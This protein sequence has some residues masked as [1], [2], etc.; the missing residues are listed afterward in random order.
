KLPLGIG[1]L[2]LLVLGGMTRLAW[3]DLRRSARALAAERLNRV[4]PDLAAGLAG[5]A[6]TRSGSLGALA[7]DS[8]LTRFLAA[9][10]D[11]GL[12]ERVEEEIR[13][14]ADEDDAA[15][16]ELWDSAARRVY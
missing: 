11:V 12:R 1:L 10:G 9:G 8:V 6:V 13:D 16:I 2:L 15:V 14:Y 7:R 3:V 4:T 5:S